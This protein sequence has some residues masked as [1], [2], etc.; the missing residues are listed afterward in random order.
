MEIAQSSHKEGFTIS[1]TFLTNGKPYSVNLATRKIELGTTQVNLIPEDFRITETD[2]FLSP[3]LYEK[4]FGLKFTVDIMHLTLTLE[5]PHTLPVQERKAREKVRKKMGTKG[6]THAYF[7]LLS[8]RKRSFFSGMMVDYSLNGYYSQSL[9][10]AFGYTLTGGAE[11]LGGDLVGTVMGLHSG[12]APAQV[13]FSGL[14]W[15]YTV[16][17]SSWFTS[18]TLGNMVTSGLQPVSYT[19]LSLTNDPIEPRRLFDHHVI[20]GYT[21]PQSE[22]EL[23]VNERITDF[24]RANELGYYRFSIPVQYGSTRISTK[25]YTPSGKTIFNDRQ[26][27]IPFNFLPP[28]TITYNL[29]GG[30]SDIGYTDTVGSRWIGQGNVMAG[31]THWLTAAAGMQHLGNEFSLDELFWY[32]NISARI[33][34]QYLASVDIAPGYFSRVSGNVLYASNRSINISYTRFGE[35]N[36]Y[37][38]REA[39]EELSAGVYMPFILFGLSSGFR[40]AGEHLVLPKNSLTRIR[41][42]VSTRIGKVN[43]RVFYRDNLLITGDDALFGEGVLTGSILY[44]HSRLPGV[45]VFI[46]GMFL[47]GQIEYDIRRKQLYTTEIQYSKTILKNG[48]FTVT[49]GYNALTKLWYGQTGLTIDLNRIRSATQVGY[50]QGMVYGQQNFSGSVG[51]DMP[52]RRFNLSNR[53]QVGRSAASVRLFVDGNSNGLYEKGEELLPY[54]AIKL[55]QSS[56]L[57]IGSDS[58]VRISQIQAYYRYNVSMNRSA[59]SDPTLVP[60]LEN[61]SFIAD[62]NRYKV[63]DIPCYRGGTIEGKV[64]IERNGKLTG[65]GGLRVYLRNTSGSEAKEMV[66]RTFF[67]GGFFGMDIP[68]GSYRLEIDSNQLGFLNVIQTDT[69]LIHIRALSTGDFVEGII[70]NLKELPKPL[71]LIPD[72]VVTELEPMLPV[73]T[74]PVTQYEDTIKPSIES[75]TIHIQ[76]V[77]CILQTGAYQKKEMAEKQAAKIAR[78]F[79]L[80]PFITEENKMYKVRITVYGSDEQ[81]DELMNRM[82]EQQIRV[83]IQKLHQGTLPGNGL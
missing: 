5:T 18:A 67:D 1:G 46:R 32:T 54:K 16:L 49:A 30:K 73:A 36:L 81:R 31:I 3:A 38:S 21:E 47:R 65:Q 28:G 80:Q 29:Q 40:I 42:E 75:D 19:G 12:S 77:N 78:L 8:G 64:M 11:L 55:D 58:I 83:F 37:N 51:W 4:V 52:N 71:P 45:P 79:D 33:A 63:L 41:T 56:K 10:A 50:T 57:D 61:F 20:E 13:D 43:L 53:Q 69:L 24:Q 72:S 26:M 23:Y 27:Q 17:N 22:V 15:R 35:N 7:P 62:P 60:V 14:R 70:L 25:I 34:R 48:R 74:E 82:K 76:P 2:Y 59:I 44:N 9:P 39:T 68:P 66:L 6:E